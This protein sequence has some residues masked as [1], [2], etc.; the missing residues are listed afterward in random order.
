MAAATIMT[1]SSIAKRGEL[2]IVFI[3]SYNFLLCFDY[4]VGVLWKEMATRLY[5]NIFTKLTFYLVL[6]SE[7]PFKTPKKKEKSLCC[8]SAISL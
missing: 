8:K 6:F 2:F 1:P 5:S 3:F 7:M 4:F